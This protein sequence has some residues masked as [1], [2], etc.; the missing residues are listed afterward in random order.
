M[1]F[2]KAENSEISEIM[3]IIK[4]AQNYLK[5]EGIDQWQNNY[6]NSDTIK[7]DIDKLIE[8]LYKV[9]EIFS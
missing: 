8:A 5:K 1:N 4:A 9:K 3:K 2:R 6:P 7:K